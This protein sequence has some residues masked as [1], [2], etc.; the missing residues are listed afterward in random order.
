MAFFTNAKTKIS[1]GTKTP[2]TTQTEYAADTYTLLGEVGNRGEF[3]DSANPVTWS[4]LGDGRVRKAKGV[5]DA[6]DMTVTV[7]F[8]KGDAGQGAVIAAEAD[9]SIADYNLKIEFPDGKPDAEPPVPNTIAYM[10]VKVM[11]FRIGGGGNDDVVQGTITFSINGKP[12]IV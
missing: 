11:S 1:L 10:P 4:S 9:D 7:A 2:A 12:L 5:R 6:G 3:G 8:D